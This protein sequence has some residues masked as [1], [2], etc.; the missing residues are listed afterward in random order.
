LVEDVVHGITVRISNATV[1]ISNGCQRHLSHDHLLAP[2]TRKID[3]RMI[4]DPDD[5]Y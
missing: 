4:P 2:W 5:S 1:R 3:A